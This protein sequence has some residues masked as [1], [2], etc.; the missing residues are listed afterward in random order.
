MQ[1]PNTLRY[2]K[3]HEWAKPEGNVITVGI[4]D[5]AQKSLGDIV[6]VELPKVGRVLKKLETFGVVESIKAVSDLYS[7]VDGKVIA[8]NADLT[9]DPAQINKDPHNQAWMVKIELTDPKA[10]EGLMDSGSYSKYVE[11][12]K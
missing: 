1:Y 10:I 7:P 6:Y 11:T 9:N 8:V 12:L 2:T 5:H 3:E 4:T